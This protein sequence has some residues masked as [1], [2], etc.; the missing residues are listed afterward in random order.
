VLAKIMRR[1][2]M[3]AG[4]DEDAAEDSWRRMLAFFEK[5]R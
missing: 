1:T 5:H 3:H 2:P 4:Y